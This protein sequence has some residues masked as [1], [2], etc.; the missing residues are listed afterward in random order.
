MEKQELTWEM[1]EQA[2]NENRLELLED[3]NYLGW[4]QEEMRKIRMKYEKPENK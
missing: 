3:Y 2:L 1:I 4:L